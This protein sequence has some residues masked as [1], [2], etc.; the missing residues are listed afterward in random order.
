[1]LLS[2]ILPATIAA[3]CI[4]ALLKASLTE[5]YLESKSFSDGVDSK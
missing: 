1:M 3:V 2:S 5:P 4:L